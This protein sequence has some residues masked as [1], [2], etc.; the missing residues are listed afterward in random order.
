MASK[1]TWYQSFAASIDADQTTP[2]LA[3]ADLIFCGFLFAYSGSF[4]AHNN[5]QTKGDPR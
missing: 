2:G 5:K 3:G 1:R 4:S